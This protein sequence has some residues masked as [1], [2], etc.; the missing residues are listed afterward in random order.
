LV[1]GRWCLGWRRW[2]W[3][4]SRGCCERECELK[5]AADSVLQAQPRHN[6]AHHPCFI[7]RPTPAPWPGGSTCPAGASPCSSSPWRHLL[8]AGAGAAPAAATAAVER[9]WPRTHERRAS[10]RR[11]RRWPMHTSTPLPGGACVDCGPV[12]PG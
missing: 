8:R 4:P 12:C 1:V 10:R 11:R 5:R 2:Q 3:L 6:A 7:T 9:A